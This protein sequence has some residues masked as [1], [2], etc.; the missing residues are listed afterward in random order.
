MKAPLAIYV[1]YHTHNAKAHEIF[2]KIY[3]LFCRDIRNSLSDGLDI[4]VYF[5]TE[6]N[7]YEVAFDRAERTFINIL[8]DS[9]LVADNSTLI[10]KIRGW[11]SVKASGGKIML[12][13]VKL[14]KNAFDI[15]PTEMKEQFIVLKSYDLI[16]KSWDEYQTR[17]Y[18]SLIRF[19]QDKNS[20]VQ[21]FI[22]H[23]KKDAGKIG[24]VRAKELAQYLR[25][26]TKLNTFFDVVD[27]LDGNR[28][29]TQIEKGVENALLMI[30]YT[31]TY[32]D[33]EWCRRELIAAKD[34]NIPTV[35]VMMMD[36]VAQR[37]FPY[38]GNVPCIEYQTDWRKPINLLLKT[39]LDEYHEQLLLDSLKEGKDEVHVTPFPPELYNLRAISSAKSCVLYPEPPLGL[40]ELT[41]LRQAH[42]GINF[43]TPME[44]ASAG[45]DLQG[46]YVAISISNTEDAY[47]LGMG[48]EMLDDVSIEI[49]KHI[50]KSG[51]KMI[52][53][54]DLREGG[55]TELFSNLSS[56]Y[57]A[58]EKT[59]P[60][61]MYF[62]NFIAWP[63]WKDMTKQVREEYVHNRV[64]LVR[65]EKEKDEPTSLTKMR[66]EME[67]NAHARIV[68]GG[69]MSHYLG[70]MP[71]IIEEFKIAI[72]AGHPV[73]MVGGFGGASRYVANVLLGV[74]EV[75]DPF[76]WMKGLNISNLRNGLSEEENKRLFVSTNAM[77]IVSLILKGL[78]N[79]L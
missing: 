36:G 55:F 29:D 79:S 6:G 45:L 44:Y 42:S 34:H 23:S 24:E 77:E 75:E 26:K 52:Y 3:K 53:G 21:I 60:D 18:D 7:H 58:Y 12:S 1:V 9:N 39:A 70:S 59:D 64:E 11:L 74:T 54:G 33:R 46:K 40:E 43:V 10:G 4:P 47:K 28:F 16:K 66:V 14:C 37:V 65:V 71:G 5:A 68:A 13:P 31:N 27:I 8:S 73:Y 32:S 30:L 61:V 51:G 41:I 72:E 76:A 56:Q 67:N 50:L 63:Y 22:S 25:T 38:I 17:L 19:I 2:S 20:K 69:K 62:K 57:G 48:K 35:V 15:A 78:K 49:S